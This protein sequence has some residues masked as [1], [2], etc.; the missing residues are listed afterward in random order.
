MNSSA[1]KSDLILTQGLTILA[2]IIARDLM[3]QEL[4]K[5]FGPLKPKDGNVCTI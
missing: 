3:E 5:E 2:R 4:A 1:S